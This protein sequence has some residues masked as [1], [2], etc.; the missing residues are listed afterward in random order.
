M[1]QKKSSLK[2]NNF[3]N[4]LYTWLTSYIKVLYTTLCN[5]GR[6]KAL[7]IWVGTHILVTKEI[8][9]VTCL[10]AHI[11][12]FVLNSFNLFHD[13]G[14]LISTRHSSLTTCDTILTISPLTRL[15]R[16]SFEST[17]LPAWPSLNLRVWYHCYV[18]TVGR[19][20]PSLH[21]Y[22]LTHNSHI[23][24]G[25]SVVTCLPAHICA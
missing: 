9:D 21:A 2:R 13:V 10:P 22:E 7:C 4:F 17:A 8:P 1:S 24:K 12:S 19:K 14:L 11:C 25:I 16:V 6:N 20:S 18:T 23:T 3:F 5:D 15:L